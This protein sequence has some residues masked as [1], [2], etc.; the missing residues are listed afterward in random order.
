M[1]RIAVH[2]RLKPGMEQERVHAVVPMPEPL[3]AA[4]DN[5]GPDSGSKLVRELS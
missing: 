1:D 2:T 5:S 3:D 4:D